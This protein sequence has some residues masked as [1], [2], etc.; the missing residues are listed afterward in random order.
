MA[1]SI[2]EMTPARDTLIFLLLEIYVKYKEVSPPTVPGNT[3]SRDGDYVSIS[4]Y[5]WVS[6]TRKKT[7]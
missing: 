4:P 3:V 5:L 1:S 7:K 6:L 2:E